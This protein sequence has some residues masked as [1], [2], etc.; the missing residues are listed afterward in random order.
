MSVL[1]ASFSVWSFL[2]GLVFAY[3]V[4]P[5]LLGFISKGKSSAAKV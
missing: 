5:L 2:V 3:F 1:P 4:L